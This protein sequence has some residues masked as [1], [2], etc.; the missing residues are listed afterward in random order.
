MN[1]MLKAYDR[2]EVLHLVGEG[3]SIHGWLALKVSN[4]GHVD[5]LRGPMYCS[6][7]KYR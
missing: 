5:S 3:S 2:E 4:I 6:K 7:P 1:A